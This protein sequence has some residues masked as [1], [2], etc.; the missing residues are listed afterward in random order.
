MLSEVGFIIGPFVVQPYSLIVL[1]GVGIGA[2]VASLDLSRRGEDANL[3]FPLVIW[4]SIGAVG[5]G[6]LFYILNPPPSV[7]SYYSRDWYL[8]NL[9]DL[10]AGGIAVWSG[11]LGMAGCL[12]GA[13]AGISW[14]LVRKQRDIWRLADILTLGFLVTLSITSWANIAAKQFYGPPT[15]L[16]WGLRIPDAGK[17]FEDDSIASALAV[18]HPTPAYLSLW[19]IGTMAIVI[20]FQRSQTEHAIP[21]R[22]FMLAAYLL[23]AGLFLAD[24]LRVDINHGLLNLSGMQS[25]VLACLTAL[26]IAGSRHFLAIGL[27]RN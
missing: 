3:V 19:C 20:L 27:E 12:L 14:V 11:G 1:I 25:L 15:N 2:I 18:H 23:G 22:Y 16:P 8:A 26:G 4:G 10:Q 5:V 24:T 7:S 13:I 9:L 21:G 17:M 6:R